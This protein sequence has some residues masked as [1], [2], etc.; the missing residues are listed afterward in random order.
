M[1]LNKR[2]TLLV[3]FSQ[4]KQKFCSNIYKIMIFIW[5]RLN[6]LI[7]TTIHMKSTVT[8]NYNSDKHI[9]EFI[10]HIFTVC[11]NNW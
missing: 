1:I 5:Q 6:I 11:D 9:A 2:Q 10:L 7:F 3:N 4:Q 8:I